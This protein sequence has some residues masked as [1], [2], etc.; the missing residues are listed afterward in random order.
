MKHWPARETMKIA[1]LSHDPA[2]AG[3]HWSCILVYV[4]L[5]R[6]HQKYMAPDGL[7]FRR[8]EAVIQ[9]LKEQQ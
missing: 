1:A 5:L 3:D 9:N 6:E 8:A 4:D 2:S 7:L